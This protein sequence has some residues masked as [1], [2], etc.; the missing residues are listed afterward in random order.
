MYNYSIIIPHRN[1]PALLQRCLESIP[2]RSDLEIIII[3]DN[4]NPEIIDLKNFPGL[5]RS[6]TKVIFDKSSK[7]AGHARNIGLQYAK[8]NWLIFADADDYYS[9]DFAS[10]LDRYSSIREIDI[11]FFKCQ[12]IDDEGEKKDFIIN[13]YIDN[14]LDNR[15]L[16]LDTLKYG[17]WSPWSRMIK[18][19]VFARNHILFEEVPVGNDAWAIL[20]ASKYSRSFDVVP[21]IVYY[22]YKPKQ[23]SQTDKKYTSE[24]F[25]LRV[26]QKFRINDFYT[27]VKYPYLWPILINNKSLKRSIE[28]EKIKQKYKYSPLKDLI[29]FIRRTVAVLRGII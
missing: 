3:D 19:E 23:G 10:I 7:G 1:T 9:K 22:Y 12:I 8:G 4:S 28:L 14:Y 24:T 13:R 20:Q 18:R 21:E 25:L 6:N 27:E 11:V 26:S 17:V 16:S 5:N 15:K 2:Y 29:Y